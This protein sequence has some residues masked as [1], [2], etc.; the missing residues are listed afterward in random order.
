[1]K[2]QSRKVNGSLIITDWIDFPEGGETMESLQ[3]YLNFCYGY[4]IDVFVDDPWNN[5]DGKFEHRWGIS[6]GPW[7]SYQFRIK[8]S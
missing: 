2:W 8:N 3:K 5:Y 7:Q 6:E 4:E 1:M